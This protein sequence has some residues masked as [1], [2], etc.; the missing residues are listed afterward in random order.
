MLTSEIKEILIEVLS[1]IIGEIQERRKNLT[2][3]DVQKFFSRDKRL[4]MGK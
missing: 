4:F 1:K 2:D 3:E